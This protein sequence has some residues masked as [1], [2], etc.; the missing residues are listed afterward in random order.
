M[1]LYLSMKWLPEIRNRSWRERRQALWKAG[2]NPYRNWRVWLAMAIT[3]LVALWALDMVLG[4]MVVDPSL[5]DSMPRYVGMLTLL[6]LI[7]IPAIFVCWSSYLKA[8]RPYLLRMNLNP[9]G[10]WWGALFK[11][12]AVHLLFVLLFA[13]WMAGL[14]WAINSYDVAPDPHIAKVLSWPEPIPDA[15]NGFIYASGLTAAP[16]TAPFEAGSRWIAGVNDAIDKHSQDYPKTPDGLKY[17]PYVLPAAETQPDP[18]RRGAYAKFCDAGKGQCLSIVRQEQKQVEAWLA[19]NQELLSRYLALQKYLD[20]QDPTRPGDFSVPFMS[21]AALMS[22][23]SLMHAAV[24][25]AIEKKQTGKALEMLGDD[26]RFVRNMLGSKDSLLGKM[27]ATNMLV[28]DLAALSEIIGERPADLKPYWGQIDKMLEPLSASQLSL[29]NAYRFEQRWILS[30]T[31]HLNFYQATGV[32]VPSLPDVW[33]A[34]HFKRNATGNLMFKFWENMLKT[35]D[36]RDASY[37]PPVENLGAAAFPRYPR[38]TG[39]MHNQ[40][41]KVLALVSAPEYSQYPNRLYDLNALN[42]MV[43][44]RLALARNNVSANEVPAF[45][46]KAD[47]SLLNPETGKPFEWDAEQKQIFFIPA[48]D[49]FRNRFALAGGKSGRVALSLAAAKPR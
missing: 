22:A 25:V 33:I 15:N 30:A 6:L 7:C 49:N 44:L 19:A 21:R 9:H 36:V 34:H 24:L 2:L 13:A 40:A 14:D 46:L 20:W 35:A 39:F 18:D 31:S 28:R 11:G 38:L 3:S 42:T 10:S 41:G 17:V 27:V 23:Q 45:L 29:A 43:R 16:G 47:M 8:M 26:F 12:L 37:T 32:E 5:A 48:T 1:Q 4:M